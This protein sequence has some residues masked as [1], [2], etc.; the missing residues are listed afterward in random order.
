MGYLW[1]A[2]EHPFANFRS[3]TTL[4]KR[5]GAPLRQRVR[6]LCSK[7][8]QSRGN[9][10][11]ILGVNSREW[12]KMIWTW[13]FPVKLSDICFLRTPFATREGGRW[14]IGK[15]GGCVD[16]RFEKI[17]SFREVVKT[18]SSCDKTGLNWYRRWSY[19]KLVADILSNFSVCVRADQ[20]WARFC[21]VYSN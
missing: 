11:D 5:R 20:I 8:I 12:N 3:W 17:R 6:V 2:A 13:N 18:Q 19:C 21:T 16:P 14:N 4:E 1:L 10:G 15:L 7:G 9:S